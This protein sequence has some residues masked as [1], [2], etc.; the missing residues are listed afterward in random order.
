MNVSLNGLC[1]DVV[2]YDIENKKY[3]QLLVYAEGSLYKFS[4]PS[5]CKLICTEFIG[6]NVVV[7]A[8]IKE[9]NGKNKFTLVN[10][11]KR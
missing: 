11:T 6:S 10:I 9:Y 5:D 7:T 3:K 2:T 8:K 4:I 1:C